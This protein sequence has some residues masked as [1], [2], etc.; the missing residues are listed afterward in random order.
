[1]KREKRTGLI[2]YWPTLDVILDPIKSGN[3]IKTEQNPFINLTKLSD[4]IYLY[5]GT[6]AFVF[7]NIV[8]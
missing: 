7:D 1:M 6:N 4:A 3:G 2:L 5:I 8:I